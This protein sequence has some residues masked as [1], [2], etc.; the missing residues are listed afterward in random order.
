VLKVTLRKVQE[1]GRSCDESDG[2][3]EGDGTGVRGRSEIM[4]R[5]TGG[6]GWRELEGFA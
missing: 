6:G 2:S 1:E 4:S 5:G 3:G